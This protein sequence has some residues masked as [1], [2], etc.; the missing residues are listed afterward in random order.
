MKRLLSIL[1]LSL[2]CYFSTAQADLGGLVS[3][4]LN[5]ARDAVDAAANVT[6]DAIDTVDEGLTPHTR[7]T[8]ALG[9]EPHRVTVEQTITTY[10]N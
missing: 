4:A 6:E 7:R 9:N 8:Y 1:C 10:E 2:A 5:T 3:G